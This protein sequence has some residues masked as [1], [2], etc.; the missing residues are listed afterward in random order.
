MS[1]LK[2]NN[3]VFVLV[4]TPF[5]KGEFNQNI[6]ICCVVPA[7]D[8]PMTKTFLCLLS[9]LHNG[10]SY[11]INSIHNKIH[12]EEKALSLFFF[13]FEHSQA[14]LSSNFTTLSS[15]MCSQICISP[16]GSWWSWTLSS[17]YADVRYSRGT[18]AGIRKKTN[19]VKGLPFFSA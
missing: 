4:N 7:N 9:V 3:V 19:I 14:T 5:Q 10:C 15:A 13:S 11:T 18:W 12:L 1:K 16:Y 2:W 6:G 17:V 8:N